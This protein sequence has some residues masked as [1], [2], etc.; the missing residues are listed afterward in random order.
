MEHSLTVEHLLVLTVAN[1]W[2]SWL[3]AHPNGLAPGLTFSARVDT[4][5]NIIRKNLQWFL[6]IHFS[7]ST[8]SREFQEMFRTSLTV[9]LSNR[10]NYLYLT[11]PH[12][13]IHVFLPKV[14]QDCCP[15]QY[16]KC[17]SFSS[18]PWPSLEKYPVNTPIYHTIVKDCGLR[19]EC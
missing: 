1:V 8:L 15:F 17:F 19:T 13:D 10:Y 18:L 3:T 6:F 4:Q 11:L 2:C 9:S 12:G 7:S 16:H 5:S 14:I